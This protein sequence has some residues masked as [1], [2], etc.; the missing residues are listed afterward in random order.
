MRRLNCGV[1]LRQLAFAGLR[2]PLEKTLMKVSFR[3]TV[4][5]VVYRNG[6]RGG[7]LKSAF[8]AERN[9][10]FDRGV[11]AGSLK[12]PQNKQAQ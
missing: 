12:P 3:K 1:C 5:V 9:K 8:W 7:R 6:W 11:E 10:G 2:K 4:L